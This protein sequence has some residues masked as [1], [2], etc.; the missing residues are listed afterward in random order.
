MQTIIKNKRITG[1]LGILPENEYDYDEETKEFATSKTRRLKK[2]MGFGKRR[3][4]KA[5]TVTTD[6]CKYGLQYLLDKQYIRKEEIGAIIVVSVTPDYFL[7]QMSN[8]IQG[9]FGLSTDIICMDISQGCAAHL[10]GLLQAFM[11]L[12][13]IGNKKAL[14]F[15]GDVLRRKEK[16]APISSPIFGGDAASV[17]IVENDASAEDIYLNFYMDG[18]KREALIMHAGG[19]YMPRTPETAKLQDIGDG[20]LRSLNEIWMDGSMVF[21]FVQ[22]EV[23]PLVEE[24]I[25]MAGL[26]KDDID[27]FLFHQPNKFM[28]QK[29]AERLKVPYEKLPMNIVENFGNSSG[30]CV[31]I[32][33]T[34]NLGEKL[35]SGSYK[36]CL[37]G[38]G[39]GLTWGAAVMKLGNLDF[40]EIVTSNL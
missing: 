16:D 31:P 11:L 18:S 24:V 30:S 28:L 9:D 34:Y 40:C 39:S 6:L 38:F 14:V 20:N 33:I 8:I 19:F 12:D 23:P 10:L 22:K 21:N 5:N 29:L 35:V 37:S 32:N 3:A 2:V 1:I 13:V 4:A 27:Y 7:P 17:T 26:T 25:A 15:T 36:C